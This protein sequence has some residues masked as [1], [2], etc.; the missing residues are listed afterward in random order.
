MIG[1]YKLAVAQGLRAVLNDQSISGDMIHSAPQALWAWGWY[2]GPTDWDGYEFVNG[3][4]G[5]QLSSYTANNI[6]YIGTPGTWVPLWLLAG[7]TASWGATGEP[8]TS[9]HAH[10]AH[11]LNHFWKGYKFA[12]STYLASPAQ[13]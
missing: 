9:G 10:G 11:L 3:A 8:D 13:N 5:A 6:R 7:I 4:V 1:A 12:E 2:S